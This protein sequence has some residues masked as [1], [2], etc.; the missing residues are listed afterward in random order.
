[1]AEE[2]INGIRTVYM[3]YTVSKHSM[4]IIRLFRILFH[5]VSFNHF[6]SFPTIP[7]Y[8]LSFPI[9][10]YYSLSFPIIP[11]YSLLLNAALFS[12]VQNIFQDNYS[13]SLQR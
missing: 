2:V 13:L 6:Q 4:I 12:L 7:Y 1:M 10:S 9:I 8:S 11:Y 3:L 5:K